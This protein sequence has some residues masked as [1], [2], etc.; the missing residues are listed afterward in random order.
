VKI[1]DLLGSNQRDEQEGW[2]DLGAATTERRKS[3]K[4]NQ[5]SVGKELWADDRSCTNERAMFLELLESSREAN[6]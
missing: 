5:K 1:T 2:I 6:R 4:W 3:R